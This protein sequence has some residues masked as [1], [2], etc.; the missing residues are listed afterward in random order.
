[1]YTSIHPPACS[2][3]VQFPSTTVRLTYQMSF[4]L[5]P[6]SSS[7]VTATLFSL[8]M[9]LLGLVI[10]LF[11]YVLIFHVLSQST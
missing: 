1:M 2:P 8:R 10:Y 6:A 7:L 11:I 9:C 5:S 3:Q 4:T